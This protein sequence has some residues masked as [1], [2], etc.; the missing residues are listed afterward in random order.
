ME[1]EEEE[2]PGEGE[3]P[4]HIIIREPTMDYYEILGSISESQ[5]KV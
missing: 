3:S 1:E 5:K 4:R 2:S